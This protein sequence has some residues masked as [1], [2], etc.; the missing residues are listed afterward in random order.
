MK[1][2]RR[3]SRSPGRC[4]A[5]QPVLYSD[6][7]IVSNHAQR[8]QRPAKPT[9]TAV[10]GVSRLEV[11]SSVSR[12]SSSSSPRS[13]SQRLHYTTGPPDVGRLVMI[14]RPV[15]EAKED[16]PAIFE[17]KPMGETPHRAQQPK[18]SLPRC[19]SHKAVTSRRVPPRPSFSLFAQP[20]A[21]VVGARRR[22]GLCSSPP[23]PWELRGCCR[24]PCIIIIRCPDGLGFEHIFLGL[25]PHICEPKPF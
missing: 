17:A 8:A 12:V 2:P 7:P 25:Y 5:G 18:L 21:R 22:P 6:V 4:L 13:L 11:P 19:H 15:V 3:E 20:Y 9:R 1:G 16:E 24:S 23:R 10:S 14:H